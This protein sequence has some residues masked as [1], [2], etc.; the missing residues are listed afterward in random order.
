MKKQ[1]II[2]A[3]D[4]GLTS[5]VNEAVLK[6]Y[7]NGTLTSATIMANGLAIDEAIEIGR[8]NP[9]LG[10]GIHLNL[11][12]LKPILPPEE[13]PTL[14]DKNGH[15]T[16]ALYKLPFK[17]PGEVKKEWKAQIEHVLMLGL[18]PTHFDSH[19]HIHLYPPFT[20]VFLELA[21]E[22]GIK[23]IRLIS[24]E[25]FTIMGVTGIRKIFGKKSWSLG[26]ERCTPKTVLGI[27]NY[28]I[29]RLSQLLSS[30]DTG[31]HELYLHPGLIEDTQLEGISSL[32]DQ[33]QKDYDFL[34]DSK[35]KESLR[36]Q[37]IE[38]VNYSIFS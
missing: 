37:E 13:V 5:K 8:K 16:K 7:L 21:E 26:V 17:K 33:R 3:D 12:V 9:N 22:Y 1:I 15:F 24:P 28:S 23:A 32:K 35:L 36:K 19:H 31:V 30:L 29:S 25:S 34:M 20:K 27:E 10:I 18:K 4:F 38:L 14:V 6:S 11:T 2:N